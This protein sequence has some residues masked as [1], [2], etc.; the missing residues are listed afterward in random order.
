MPCLDECGHIENMIVKSNFDKT[1]VGD[2]FVLFLNVKRALDS[3]HLSSFH[4]K[5]CLGGRNWLVFLV[6]NEEVPKV[7]R[8]LISES[9]FKQF[10]Q[11]A[12]SKRE[13]F[14]F[15]GGD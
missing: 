9:P 8:R 3:N 13:T 11:I 4:N 5:N 7:N 1:C 6:N 10:L 14:C 12:Q 15:Q 2:I